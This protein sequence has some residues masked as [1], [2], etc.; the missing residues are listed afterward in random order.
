MLSASSLYN[1]KNNSGTELPT[2]LDKSIN[3]K[4]L[5]PLE[6]P[7]LNAFVLPQPLG[8][9]IQIPWWWM[10]PPISRSTFRSWY[11]LSNLGSYTSNNTCSIVSPLGLSPF[12]RSSDENG[13]W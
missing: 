6:R 4:F 9:L 3:T 10:I 12:N 2:P 11:A 5:Q 8:P 13:I 1:N 7:L